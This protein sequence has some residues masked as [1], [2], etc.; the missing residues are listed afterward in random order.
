MPRRKAKWSTL[1][2][3]EVSTLC[4]FGAWVVLTLALWWTPYLEKDRAV[5]GFSLFFFVLIYI[6]LGLIREIPQFRMVP[7]DLTDEQGE[8]LVRL[9][10]LWMAELRLIFAGGFAGTALTV[11][12]S[13]ALRRAVV[14]L[15]LLA[16]LTSL[17][18]FLLRWRA[19]T[20]AARGT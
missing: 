12:V 1:K 2:K 6:L 4:T 7:P 19:I 13:N 10:R 3:V 9:R 20:K 16:L 17:L 5:A 11:P 8:R 18:S 15:F 14:G